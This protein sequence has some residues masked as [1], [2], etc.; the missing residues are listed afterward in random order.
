M[1]ARNSSL[2]QVSH[3]KIPADCREVSFLAGDVRARTLSSNHFHAGELRQITCDL[4]LHSNSEIGV[5][6]FGT[7]IFEGQ[8]R[9][10]AFDLSQR[11]HALM[12]P[13]SQCDRTENYNRSGSDQ[14]KAFVTRT[15][16]RAEFC[17]AA[18]DGRQQFARC[19]RTLRW[20]DS[21]HR[22]QQR[23]HTRRH[24]SILQLLEREFLRLSC[25]NF[26]ERA[27]NKWHTTGKQIPKGHA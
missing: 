26:W 5:L 24:V 27:P 4:V 7:K 8:N 19:L 12:Q 13:R 10:R 15:C 23:N 6:D 14:D 3:T 21:Q 22:L 16:F 11:L 17:V 25:R 20:I 9:D 2:E 1:I 18:V